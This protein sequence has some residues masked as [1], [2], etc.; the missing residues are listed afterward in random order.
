MGNHAVTDFGEL[1]YGGDRKPLCA[2]LCRLGGSLFASFTGLLCFVKLSPL[3]HSAP[4][5][6]QPRRK[7]LINQETRGSETH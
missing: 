3:T 5:P 2:E 7:R 4:P 6:A 1:V